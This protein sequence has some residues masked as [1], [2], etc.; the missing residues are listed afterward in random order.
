VLRKILL[1]LV[2]LV[3]ALGAAELAVRW[4]APQQE[5]EG[6][7]FLQSDDQLG[8]TLAPGYHGRFTNLVDFDIGIDINSLGLRGGEL[9][10]RR[11]E[12]LGLGDSFMFGHGVEAEESF[13]AVAAALLGA[14]PVDAGVPG[15][16]LCQAA[17]LGDR[18][19]DRVAP[20]AIVIAACLANDELDETRGR[21][22]I[23]VRYGF[24]LEPGSHFDPASPARRLRHAV[25]RH[26]HLVRLI[27]FSPLTEAVSR[28]LGRGESIDRRIVRDLLAAYEVPEL[29][30]IARGD[31]ESETCLARLAEHA[32]ERRIPLVGVLIPD[33]LEIDPAALE[34]TRR[35]AGEQGIAL[36]PLGPRRRLGAIF[37]RV[38]IAVVD[39]SRPLR[40]AVAGG[41]RPW[42]SQDRHFTPLGH[43]VVGEQ[44]ADAL[45]RALDTGATPPDRPP[46]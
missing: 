24:A 4:L 9:T 16:D 39:P 12:L 42:F 13:L 10:E 44:L 38:G 32:R 43:R 3:V 35:A 40:A 18:L 19:L 30:E 8:W 46:L 26:S 17:D 5:V 7:R 41:Q 21:R 6:E 11:P 27:R 36:D 33:A 45:A 1:V 31:A 22:R 29:P 20:A 23:E 37:R 28:W 34:R 15:Y 25:Y 14:Q 2:S